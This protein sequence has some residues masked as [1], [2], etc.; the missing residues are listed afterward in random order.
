V[1]V[2][3]AKSKSGKG[4]A[5]DEIVYGLLVDPGADW[6][7]GSP[8]TQGF[9]EIDKLGPGGDY[10]FLPER[11]NRYWMP[12]LVGLRKITVRDFAAGAQFD[13]LKDSDTLK[14]QW[15]TCA[16]FSDLDIKG[17]GA[18]DPNFYCTP[19]V[20]KDFF[21]LLSRRPELRKVV[22]SVTL[23]LP[24]ERESLPPSIPIPPPPLPK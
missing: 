7:L 24:L 10:F 8:A 2:S 12:V 4:G 15:T 23:G 19:T 11:Q 6:V 1:A 5:D 14:E 13:G 9:D 20:T 17:P 18:K 22:A 21:V 16:V 3:P